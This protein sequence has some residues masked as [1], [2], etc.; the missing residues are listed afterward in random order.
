VITVAT[1][2]R[3]NSSGRDL[4]QAN[5][6]PGED[7]GRLV[8]R[9]RL[10]WIAANP[11]SADPARSLPPILYPPPSISC[12]IALEALEPAGRGGASCACHIALSGRDAAA[13]AKIGISVQSDGFVPAGLSQLLRSS[14][15][16]EL[17]HSSLLSPGTGAPCAARPT[18]RRRPFSTMRIGHKTPPATE[19]ER[20]TIIE[21]TRSATAL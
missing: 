9:E 17:G 14:G 13:L 21:A 8:R 16:Q 3:M 10:I 12:A 1:I 6:R 15:L 2:A 19:G 7:R 4:V 20:G 18:R 11:A 5:R